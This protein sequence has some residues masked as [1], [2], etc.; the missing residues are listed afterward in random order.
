MSC[1]GTSA[2]MR[3][4]HRTAYMLNNSLSEVRFHFI[5]RINS[6]GFIYLYNALLTPFESPLVVLECVDRVSSNQSNHESRARTGFTTKRGPRR[7]SSPSHGAR[8]RSGLITSRAHG[9][10]LPR[11]ADHGG[12]LHQATERAHG[13]ASSRVA[14]TD[15]IYHEARNTADI[16]TKY[17]PRR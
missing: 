12:Y 17:G 5:T 13:R 1:A 16:F 2:V 9:R 7:I 14:R 3:Y 4:D 11:S 15:E 8:A 6:N 10:V